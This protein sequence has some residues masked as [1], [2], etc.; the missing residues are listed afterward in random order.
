VQ[1]IE[2]LLHE[3]EERRLPGY[4]VVLSTSSVI[5]SS[6]GVSRLPVTRD[7][8]NTRLTPT[9]ESKKAAR[10]ENPIKRSYISNSPVSL[11]LQ[12]G[13][14]KQQLQIL[15]SITPTFIL[16]LYQLKLQSKTSGILQLGKCAIST[17]FF[18]WR[19]WGRQPQR[20]KMGKRLVN[21]PA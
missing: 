21:A 1:L 16:L 10:N 7:L 3:K 8:F 4:G 9:Q 18:F 12:K 17:F 14:R 15:K 20:D 19:F 13:S 2:E 5:S 11:H 6:F